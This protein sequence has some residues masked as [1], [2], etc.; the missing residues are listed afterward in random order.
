MTIYKIYILLFFTL[1]ICSEGKSQAIDTTSIVASALVK[2]ISFRQSIWEQNE[3]KELIMTNDVY[4]REVSSEGFNDILFFSLTYP[5]Y[6]VIIKDLG[7]GV[8]KT[9]DPLLVSGNLIYAYD[10]LTNGLYLLTE[11][12]DLRAFKY[13]I[14]HRLKVPVKNIFKKKAW[15]KYIYIDG[16]DLELL[17]TL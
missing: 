8:K 5:K 16:I 2:S 3:I 10:K 15:R 14:Q 1:G 17:R 6:G 12:K 9:H 7:A 13:L 4:I 11:T